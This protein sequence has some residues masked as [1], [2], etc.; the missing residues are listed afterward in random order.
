V[1]SQD[2]RQS[3][4]GSPAFS[5]AEMPAR[6]AGAGLPADDDPVVVDLSALPR[7]VGLALWCE[8]AR[9]LVAAKY[10]PLFTVKTT[11]RLVDALGRYG[12]WTTGG[13]MRPTWARLQRELGRSRR[14][15]AYHLA[16]LRAAGLLRIDEHGTHLTLT[17]RIASSYQALL[18]DTPEV[19]AALAQARSNLRKAEA[20]RPRRCIGQRHVTGPAPLRGRAERARTRAA[21]RP[22]TR[23][24]TPS[25]ASGTKDLHPTE[26]L[27]S[28][29]NLTDSEGFSGGAEEAQKAAAKAGGLMIAK[30]LAAEVPQFRGLKVELA[31]WVLY[32]LVKAGWTY[33]DVRWWLRLDRLPRWYREAV[34]P[35]QLYAYADPH[36][37]RLPESHHVQN[38]FG[39]LAFRCSGRRWQE[40]EP[41]TTV[42][43]RLYRESLRMAAELRTEDDVLVEESLAAD[44]AAAERSG[45]PQVSFTAQLRAPEPVPAIAPAA[46]E[47]AWAGQM[48]AALAAAAEPE[49]AYRPVT[50]QQRLRDPAPQAPTGLKARLASII[51]RSEVNANAAAR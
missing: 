45:A 11:C 43:R 14:C 28:P 4:A 12:D 48:Q 1:T 44:R 16:H 27:T 21:K 42:R 50:V 13:E 20:R 31:A 18:P 9:I 47:P 38:P 32:P 19:R 30:K 6:R 49:P 29:K 51:A 5:L 41:V 33:E 39:L 40:W 3:E 23:R 22:V 36:R 10:H 15:V 37:G 25:T 24:Q 35:E 8:T 26:G 17:V 2:D 46:E 7:G 34:G